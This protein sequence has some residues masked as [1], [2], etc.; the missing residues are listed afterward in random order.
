MPKDVIGTNE[1]LQDSGPLL[2]PHEPRPFRIA[3]ANGRAPLL[4]TCD[5]ASCAVPQSLDSLGLQASDL[6]RHIGWDRGAAEAT[7]RL[8]KRFD[9][10]AIMTRYSRLVIDCN[11]APRTAALDP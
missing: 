9:A 11:R 10:P 2:A 5:H 7:V 3:N 4:F 8:S 6:Q 1:P